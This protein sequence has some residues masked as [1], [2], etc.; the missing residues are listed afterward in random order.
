[1]FLFDRALSTRTSAI[2]VV[3]GL[4]GQGKT[5][6]ID[7]ALWWRHRTGDT[8]SIVAVDAS[9]AGTIEDIVSQIRAAVDGQFAQ[10]SGAIL[11]AATACPLLLVIDEWPPHLTTDFP[12][13][14]P[15]GALN[16]LLDLIDN[17]AANDGAVIIASKAPLPWLSSSRNV[18]ELAFGGLDPRACVQLANEL[19]AGA[20]PTN[21]IDIDEEEL[22][23]LAYCVAGNPRSLEFVAR[24]IA[25]G[26]SVSKAKANFRTGMQIFEED[27]EGRAEVALNEIIG[28]S[29]NTDVAQ[30]IV[31]NSLDG[32][33]LPNNPTARKLQEYGLSHLGVPHPALLGILRRRGYS[34]S[35][36]DEEE[37]TALANSKAHLSVKR[38]DW[39]DVYAD[40]AG[41]HNETRQEAFERRQL[42]L[43]H[44]AEGD[45][46][47]ARRLLRDGVEFD[48]KLEEPIAM[49]MNLSS[50]AE[51]EAKSGNLRVAEE[52]FHQAVWA[53]EL[54]GRQR[55]AAISY[56]Q[57]AAA[58]HRAG[59]DW[60][61]GELLIA[62]AQ[63]FEK[64]EDPT[65]E[66][67]R[68]GYQN[69]VREIPENIGRAMI[70]SWEDAGLPSL[71]LPRLP[72]DRIR[73]QRHLVARLY[74]TDGAPIGQATLPIKDIT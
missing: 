32:G 63:L 31:S 40:S 13:G 65:G 11:S 17:L 22:H 69:Y 52:A 72:E 46:D 43:R 18:S 50:L 39:R 61:A 4:A 12:A 71:A 38:R 24:A 8:R 57:W 23:G 41:F 36:R 74:D 14:N 42:A 15:E 21:G 28:T 25:S 73:G 6:F 56:N 27:F 67:V 9:S 10:G 64:M 20:S 45:Y 7:E 35:G 26:H 44:A 60:S 58:L 70:A 5:R 66:K 16:V 68:W 29:S 47:E 49:A 33:T 54:Y 51:V 37:F 34:A 59:R 3:H 1:M 30:L 62:A 55:D 19:I 2:V 53:F 48:A